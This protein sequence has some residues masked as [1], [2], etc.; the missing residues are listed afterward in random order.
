MN[1]CWQVFKAIISGA[2]NELKEL[3]GD[4]VTLV[5]ETIEKHIN[6]FFVQ[7]LQL[8]ELDKVFGALSHQ[9]KYALIFVLQ[10]TMRSF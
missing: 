10:H 8:L 7:A 9:N 3:L 5:I 1:P 6:C 2:L 4:V